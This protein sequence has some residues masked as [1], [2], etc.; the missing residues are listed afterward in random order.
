MQEIVSIFFGGGG[1]VDECVLWL[2]ERDGLSEETT[3]P[4]RAITNEQE[5]FFRSQHS[6][7]SCL[8]LPYSRT[9]TV[10][11]LHDS[12]ISR[13]CAVHHRANACSCLP[14]IHTDI[15]IDGTYSVRTVFSTYSYIYVHI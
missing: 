3:L 6:R 14:H 8:T 9:A 10:L 11:L 5:Y 1:G 13:S 7:G 12:T 2:S 4:H 15:C